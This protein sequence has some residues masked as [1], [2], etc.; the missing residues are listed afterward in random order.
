MEEPWMNF[1]VLLSPVVSGGVMSTVLGFLFQQRT[2]KIEEQTF[3]YSGSAK[4]QMNLSLRELGLPA[5][6]LAAL[7]SAAASIAGATPPSCSSDHEQWFCVVMGQDEVAKLLT[8]EFG[9]TIA[10][11]MLSQTS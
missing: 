1:P 3:L 5:T 4:S 10:C 6:E 9:S 8:T 7:P 11:R 2:A